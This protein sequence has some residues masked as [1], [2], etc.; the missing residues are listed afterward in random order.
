MSYAPSCLS[1]ICSGILTLT[2]LKKYK[3]L[4]PEKIQAS[5]H[6]MH[7]CVVGPDSIPLVSHND[8]PKIDNGK[9]QKLKVDESIYGFQQS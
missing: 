1:V 2:V 7:M 6:I 3:S 8:I 4:P 9:F 5:M